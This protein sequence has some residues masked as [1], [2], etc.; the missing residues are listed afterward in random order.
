MIPAPFIWT[1][2]KAIEWRW[3]IAGIRFGEVSFSTKLRNGALIDLY[4]KVIG[5]WFLLSVALGAWFG[6][7]LLAR[8]DAQ[9]EV[10]FKIG[11]DAGFDIRFDVQFKTGLGVQ[12]GIVAR[13]GIV[14]DALE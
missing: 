9:L 6:A 12:P 5:W 14:A 2:I 4:W 8:L 11:P 13:L 1:E 10:W 3:W 7:R